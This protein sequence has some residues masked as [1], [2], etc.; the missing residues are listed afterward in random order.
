M[1][2][3]SL[4]LFRVFKLLDQDYFMIDV[5]KLLIEILDLADLIKK[6]DIIRLRINLP[7]FST[8]V[9]A[10]VFFCPVGLSLL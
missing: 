8:V 5:Q 3:Y 1:C 9:P 4:L 7:L 2:L 6:V 10:V